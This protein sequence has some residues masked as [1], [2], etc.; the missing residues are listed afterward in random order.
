MK[1]VDASRTAL[2]VTAGSL[3]SS[4]WTIIEASTAIVCACLPMRR[5]P[6]QRLIPR[7]F[8]GRVASGTGRKARP[9]PEVSK[10]PV[11]NA[12][13]QKKSLPVDSEEE[14]AAGV[15]TAGNGRKSEGDQ[16]LEMGALGQ[17]L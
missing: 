9:G 15:T 13:H 16:D 5:T 17:G 10:A 8:P 14:S 6:V 1:A 2:D 12:A 3:I 7:L 11:V 4:M